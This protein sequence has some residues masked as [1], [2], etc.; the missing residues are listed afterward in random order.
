MSTTPGVPVPAAVVL[1]AGAGTRL[2]PLTEIRPKALCPVGDRPLLDWALERVGA[3]S[4]RVA[5][6]AHHHAGQ[7]ADHLGDRGVHLSVEDGQALGT[8]GALGHLRDWV[9][10]EPVLL[11]NADAWHPSGPDALGPLVDGWTGERPRLLCVR[12]PSGGDFGDLRYVGSALLPWWSVRDLRPVPSGLYEV[13]WR[14]LAERDALELALAPDEPVDC[15]TP[16]DYLRANL[17]WSGGEPVIGA[18]AVVEGEV[19]RSVVWP[20]ERV[21]PGERLVDA[22]RAG[23]RTVPAGA[24]PADPDAPPRDDPDE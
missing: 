11:T 7:V 3:Y 18:G 8:A 13:S 17:R 2:R 6:N 15:G 10:G 1:A 16:A 24:G 21:G 12:V 20:G 14:A 19:V 5:V 22:I 4:R 23:G 9:D